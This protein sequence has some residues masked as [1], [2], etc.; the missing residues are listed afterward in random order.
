MIIRELCWW[1]RPGW[2][3]IRVIIASINFCLPPREL[4]QRYKKIIVIIIS[5]LTCCLYASFGDAQFF[6]WRV[7]TLNNHV[8]I[9]MRACGAFDVNHYADDVC[10]E[11][12]WSAQTSYELGST[13]EPSVGRTVGKPTWKLFKPSTTNHLNQ[14]SLEMRV[15]TKSNKDLH[16][17]MYSSFFLL[18]SLPMC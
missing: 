14:A 6:G 9:L 7:Q 3:T 16:F 5:V 17:Q 8:A 4:L 12:H 1:E 18:I 15:F 13:A 2:L 11:G 10:R